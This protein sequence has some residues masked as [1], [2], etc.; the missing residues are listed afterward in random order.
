MVCIPV[1]P[2]MWDRD[3]RIVELNGQPGQNH[4]LQV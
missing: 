4:E 3:K 1:T 2:V